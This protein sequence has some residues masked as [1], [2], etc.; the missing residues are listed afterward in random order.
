MDEGKLG[1]GVSKLFAHGRKPLQ[2][3]LPARRALFQA[4]AVSQC[5]SGR[6]A[7][8]SDAVIEAQHPNPAALEYVMH[9]RVI[10]RIG[11]RFG[12][13]TNLLQPSNTGKMRIKSLG[14]RQMRKRLLRKSKAL[15]EET[16]CAAGIDQISC[17][18]QERLALLFAAQAESSGAWFRFS[19][20]NTFEALN[21]VRLGFL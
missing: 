3:A 21:A 17:F 14:G 7:R 13:R 12:S 15:V 1:L 11:R 20:V 6:D 5:R 19:K 2:E 8:T 9:C 16:A 18:E 10:N 4:Q